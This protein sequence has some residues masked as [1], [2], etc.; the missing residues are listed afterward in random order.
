M[1]S[2]DFESSYNLM[3]KLTSSQDAT[4]RSGLVGGLGPARLS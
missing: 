3:T 1:L 4:N 2:S